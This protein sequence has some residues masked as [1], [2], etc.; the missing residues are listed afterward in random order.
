MKPLF[1]SPEALL[2]TVGIV[3]YIGLLAFPIIFAC[4]LKPLGKRPYCWGFYLAWRA[5]EYAAASILCA[6]AAS[7]FFFTD[8]SPIWVLSA[9]ISG[10]ISGAMIS[11]A[12]ALGLCR[13]QLYGVVVLMAPSALLALFGIAGMIGILLAA[14]SRTPS[15]NEAFGI[16]FVFS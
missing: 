12:A 3:F 10:A 4:H 11:C 7:A 16:F 9:S 8:H 13:R 2:V 6:I 14:Q 5:A 1:G 15:A